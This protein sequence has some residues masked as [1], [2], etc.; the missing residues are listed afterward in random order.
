[1]EKHLLSKSTFIRGVQC[2][3]SLYLNKKRPFL[4]DRMPKERLIVFQRGHKVGELAQELFPGGINM[5]PGHPG[6]FKKAIINTIQKIEEGFPVI[7]EAAF[8]YDQVIIFLDVLVHTGAGWHAYEVKSSGGI[9]DTYLMDAALQYHVIKGAGIELNGISL[10]HI[11]REYILEDEIEVSKMFKIINVNDEALS[12][13]EYVTQQILRE[14]DALNLEHS[15]KI[16]VGSHCRDPYDCDFLGHCWKNIPKAPAQA[17]EQQMDL[18]SF[19][20][21]SHEFSGHSAFLRLMPMLP[22]VPMYRGSHPYQSIVYAYSILSQDG[23]ETQSMTFDPVSNPEENLIPALKS[24]L[25]GISNI[26]CFGQSYLIRRIFPDIPVLDL[27]NMIM[28]ESNFF[29]EMKDKSELEKLRIIFNIQTKEALPVY[30]SDAIAEH[31]YLKDFND[32]DV[33]LNI[34][35]YGLTWVNSLK[36]LY[37]QFH[38]Q[39]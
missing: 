22:A 8:Q 9:S 30:L 21:I 16:D 1:M 24:D 17:P 34:K 2:L 14:K 36:E 28:D 20:K 5:S 39:K 33:K 3:K 38:I 4:R 31:Y 10:V 7:Y 26:I 19:K 37:N 6:A 15:P 11:D 18:D 35:N 32:S 29:K 13:Q 27:R 23:E 12:R 25:G